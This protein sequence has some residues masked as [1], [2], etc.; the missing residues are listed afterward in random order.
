MPKVMGHPIL[1]DSEEAGDHG[2][3]RT[4]QAASTQQETSVVFH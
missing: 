2:E 4:R 1:K 3:S